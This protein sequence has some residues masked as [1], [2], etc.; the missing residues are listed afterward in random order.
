MAARA[1]AERLRALYFHYLSRTGPY[2]GRD[3]DLALSRAVLAI[4]A[5]KEP[6]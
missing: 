6:E 5:D 3:R 4:R 2:A 1:K